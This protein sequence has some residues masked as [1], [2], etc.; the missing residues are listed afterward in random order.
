M[1]LRNGFECPHEKGANP[2]L[3]SLENLPSEFS[4]GLDLDFFRVNLALALVST[5][6]LGIYHSIFI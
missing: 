1:R 2:Y 6:N 5:I 4:S 3:D